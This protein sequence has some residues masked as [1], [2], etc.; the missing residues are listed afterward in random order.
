LVYS[1]VY[2]CSPEDPRLRLMTS[3]LGDEVFLC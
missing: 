2:G 3:R 1:E